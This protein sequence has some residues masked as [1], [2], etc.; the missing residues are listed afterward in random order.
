MRVS[1]MGREKERRKKEAALV[2]ELTLLGD[3]M[4]RHEWTD[5]G[6]REAE[7]EE[8]LEAEL[9]AEVSRRPGT[10]PREGGDG[11][12]AGLKIPFRRGDL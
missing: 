4:R 12:Q 6:L 11:A 8:K 9:D 5:F 2:E 3:M 10:S 1:S 7:E